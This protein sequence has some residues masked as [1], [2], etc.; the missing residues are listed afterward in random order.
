MK[1]KG[2][3]IPK[4]DFQYSVN[5][6]FD[7]NSE[8][9]IKGYIPTLGGLNIIEDVMLSA[10]PSSKDRA[11]LFVGAYGKGKSHLVLTILS[12]LNKKDKNLFTAVLNKAK[13]ENPKF[14]TYLD[15]YIDSNSRLLPVV[16]QGSS[17]DTTT[18]FLLSLKN[19][20]QANG[21]EEVLPDT[22]FSSVISIIRRWQEE[23][24]PTFNKFISLIGENV[25]K[26]I[27]KL[28]L[29]DVETYKKF[30]NLYPELTSGSQF[31]PTTGLD[32]V[33]VYEDVAKKI[34]NYGY[35]GIFVVY[36]E[37][38]KFLENSIGSTSAM[39]IKMIQ[40]FA[41][42]CNRSGDNQLHLLL[43]SH[44]HIQN[45]ISQ[46][47]KEKVDAWKAVSE[48]FKTIEINNNFTQTY[49][50]VS[51]VI[52][53]NDKWFD[54]FCEENYNEFAL[55][56]ESSA[57][58]NVFADIPEET[59]KKLSYRTYPL[60][61]ASLFILPRISELVAQNER[62][63]FTFLASSQK[64]SL[65][66]FI[67]NADE[68]FPLITPDYIYDY[69]EQLFKNENYNS[70]TFKTWENCKI[71][72]SKLESK[73]VNALTYK[74]LKALALIII[75]QQK[76]IRLT[77]TYETLQKIYI[78]KEKSAE[79]IAN[80]FKEL[81][82]FGVINISEFNGQISISKGTNIDIQKKLDDIMAKQK[83]FFDAKEQL[84]KI[85][86][87]NYLFP[88]RYNDENA[89][90]RFFKTQFIRDSEILEIN[91]WDKKIASVN[92]DGVVYL[93]LEDGSVNRSIIK[94]KL[95]EIK[96]DRVVFVRLA[97]QMK[98]DKTLL[99]MQA[100]EYIY[101]TTGQEDR[102]LIKD[103][104]DVHYEDCMN[105][106]NSFLDAYLRPELQH[107]IYINNG[108]ELKKIK[109]KSSISQLLS[110]ICEKVFINTPRINNEL[111]NKNNISTP[112]YNARNKVIAAL[113]QNQ[114]QQ[115]LGIVG[116]G[117]ENNIMRSMLFA[118]GILAENSNMIV[119]DN[120][121]DN[122][123]QLVIDTIR[124]FFIS[125]GVEKRCFSELYDM[126]V[127]PKH[128][129][130][131]KRGVIPVYIAAVLNKFKQHA[132]VVNSNGFEVEI[133]AETLENI[134]KNPSA[135]S[136]I[137]EDWN[138]NKQEY[139]N[140]LDEIFIKYIV[141]A[142]REYNTF[143]YIVKAMQRWFM[144]LSKFSKE[145]EQQYVGA[146]QFEKVDIKLKKFRNQLK[147]ADLNSRELLFDKIPSIFN[148]EVGVKLAKFV[149]NAKEFFETSLENTVDL[150]GNDISKL[151]NGKE[152][153]S[154]ISIMKDWEESLKEETKSYFFNN[155][156]EYIF[157]YIRKSENNDALL[158]SQIT[159]HIT[160]LRFSDWSDST[161]L[162]F[163]TNMTNF[164]KEVEEINSKTTES[165]VSNTGL[166]KISYI[167]ENGN[168]ETKTLTRVESSKHAKLL[169]NDIRSILED[170]GESIST[171]EKRQ[172]L[173]DIL[174]ELK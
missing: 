51:T 56:Q 169:N 158:F 76:D 8:E 96:N 61:S 53:K 150:V 109:R 57:E 69:F 143:D 119:L 115:N 86:E 140:L 121:P 30:V 128:T 152:N 85:I 72:L 126:L 26:V 137:L 173:L 103:E 3:I 132:V 62:T 66:D 120:L 18:S 38:S 89:I 142:E 91:D 159:K 125:C 6:D 58:L 148:L 16:I 2:N 122:K 136:L 36:D 84:N 124:N 42:M 144:Q 155:K 23:Y 37:F 17:A 117:P 174:K 112:L 22:Y 15:N 135:F 111:I 101:S 67:N 40:D 94:E 104:L 50:I 151:F 65:T 87:H 156:N 116:Q 33:K 1:L 82:S 5:I 100:L 83:N 52:Q 21:L 157:D 20:L 34:K 165:S 149:K 81:K 98:I 164:K 4:S 63:I 80:A 27:N 73:T 29:F 123:V 110:E 102:E 10:I 59:A 107:C 161:I 147:S 14:Y 60:D 25:E 28:E 24:K 114:I 31:I 141:P 32:V 75:L 90:V 130:A 97:K 11:R 95:A 167:D 39:E 55:L 48:R 46:L 47:P 163:L 54:K 129:I 7:L 12:L 162:D 134:N 49:E 108:N 105:I 93:V 13:A 138:E 19:A 43:I 133:K 44:K 131:L 118:S 79:K 71:A 92:A 35:N 45:Y 166:Y 113:L 41:E 74:L 127:L 77:P 64:N 139:I 160:G 88:S 70:I 145:F 171:N 9:K 68:D 106:F 153:A 154:F 78:P 170:F 146:G 99:K 172:V 168:E